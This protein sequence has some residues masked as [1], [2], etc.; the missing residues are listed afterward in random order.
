VQPNSSDNLHVD[1]PMMSDMVIDLSDLLDIRLDLDL[2]PCPPPHKLKKFYDHIS[3]FQ[4]E[5]VVKLFYVEGVLAI[6]DVLH[7]VRCKVC[8][9][10]NRKPCLLTPK[11]DTLIKHEGKRNVKK[12]FLKLNI[13]K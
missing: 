13:R 5:W 12:D 4:L 10:I 9:I 6:D 3:N 1:S 8:N 11:W 7:N 2:L